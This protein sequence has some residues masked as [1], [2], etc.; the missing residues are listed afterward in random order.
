MI[1]LDREFESQKQ[2]LI[3]ELKDQGISQTEVLNSI[4]DTPRQLFVDASLLDCAYDN[5][6]L[7]IGYEQTISQPYIVALMTSAALSGG[8]VRKVLEIG[9]GS[10][11]QTAILARCVDVVFTVER[12]AA[13]QE[14]AK[15]VLGNLDIKNVHYLCADGAEG[16]AEEAPFDAILVTANAIKVPEALQAQVGIGGRLVIP[17]GHSTLQ[18]LRCLS[19]NTEDDWTDQALEYV[20]F[21][22]L[23]EGCVPLQDAGKI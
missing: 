14:Q 19:R 15:I 23:R 4:R 17:V 1:H 5:R 2:R 12:L 18:I 10:G 9:T 22:P 20:R 21:V 13:L 8:G 7:P 6:P 3:K 11:Y 16:W